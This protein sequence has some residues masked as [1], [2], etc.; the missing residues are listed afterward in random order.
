MS[1][2][3]K[4]TSSFF[5]FLSSEKLSFE[6]FCFLKLSQLWPV[7]LPDTLEPDEGASTSRASPAFYRSQLS[8]ATPASSHR[9][10]PVRSNPVGA[11]APTATVHLPSKEG[12]T[13]ETEPN[14]MGKPATTGSGGTAGLDEVASESI[15]GSPERASASQ[16]P[17]PAAAPGTRGPSAGPR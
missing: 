13:G 17:T 3:P 1:V 16:N 2:T 4:S 14:R 8:K 10:N 9:S 15:V 7:S 11:G 6:L 5:Y 12:P